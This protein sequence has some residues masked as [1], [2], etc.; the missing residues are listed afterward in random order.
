MYIQFMTLALSCSEPLKFRI[1]QVD[2]YVLVQQ[3]D[4]YVLVQQVDFYVL[5]QFFLFSSI[6]ANLRLESLHNVYV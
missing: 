5:V 6:K 3:V 1:Q 4:F 2:F